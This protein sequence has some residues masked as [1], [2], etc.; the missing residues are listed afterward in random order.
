MEQIEQI[1]IGKILSPVGLRGEVKVYSYSDKPERFAPGAELLL[2]GRPVRIET[3]RFVKNLPIIKLDGVENREEAE[4]LR[5]H[6]LSIGALSLT[7]L[8]EGEWYVR[9]LIGCEVCD[10]DGNALGAIADVL[11]NGAQDLYEI[12]SRDG[13]TFL[14]P[15]VAAFVVRVDVTAKRVVARVPDGIMELA[16]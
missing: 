8:P 15:A 6:A 7:P 14:L 2:D 1:E 11:Q 16:T 5:G 4:A 13:R 10:E 9:D 3:S 12:A